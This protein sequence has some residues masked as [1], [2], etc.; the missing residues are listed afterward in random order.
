MQLIDI[1]YLGFFGVMIFS[2]L[3]W[4]IVYAV[5]RREVHGSPKPTRYPSITFLVPAYNE[6]DYIEDT[7]QALLDLNYPSDRIDIIAINDGSDDSTLEKLQQFASEIEIID[8]ENQGKAAALN[9]ALERVETELVACMDAD[10]TPTRD[11]LQ[12]IVGYLQ[13]PRVKGV[14]PALKVGNPQTWVQKIIWTEYVFQI[15]LRKMFAIFDA[16]WVLPG[17]G[18]VYDTEYLK[19]LGGWDEET[20]TEDMEVAFRMFADGARIENSS[21]AYVYTVSPPTIRGLFRQRI[22]WY[23]GYIENFLQYRNLMGDRQYGNMGVFM[24]PF[25]IVWLCLIIFLFTHFLVRI[26]ELG[27]QQ[28]N[29]FLLIGWMPPSLDISLMSITFFHL[30]FTF[31]VLL[32]IGTILISIKTADEDVRLWERKVHYGTFLVGYAFLFAMFWIAAFIEEIRRGEK[33]W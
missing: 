2:S 1:V 23:R 6:E 3:L 10:S 12:H 8:Q 20:L 27:V 28:V 24:L 29:T 26:F 21:N 18:S 33:R 31:F 11:Y 17:P 5:N 9:N 22:R 30:F 7:I 14:T 16:Q 25:N 32:G 15:F 4:L 13:R 19:E